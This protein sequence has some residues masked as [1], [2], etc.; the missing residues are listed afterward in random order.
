MNIT[1]HPLAIPFKR[2]VCACSECVQCCKEQPGFL[3]PGDAERIAAFTGLPS[4]ATLSA[5]PGG[6]VMDK[7]KG[8]VFS[9]R[10]ITPQSNYKGRCIF[11][12]PEDKCS[13]H[14][15]APFGCAYC[16]THMSN[17]SGHRVSLWGM[18]QVIGDEAYSKLRQGL[19]L[20]K[21]YKP[22][23][24]NHNKKPCLQK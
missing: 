3:I 24:F 1:P 9:V 5:S 6:L 16:D 15:V 10:T 17:E 4:S 23:K 7:Q 20:S 19:P 14:P 21:S 2:T 13:I 22:R 18:Q 8:R 12:T 11:L